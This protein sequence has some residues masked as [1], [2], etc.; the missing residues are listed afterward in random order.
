MISQTKNFIY[1]KPTMQ[2]EKQPN[3]ECQTQKP[4]ILYYET[5]KIK[6]RKEKQGSNRKI[7][8]R[9]EKQ[10]C[11]RKIKRRKERN[12]GVTSCS[13]HCNGGPARSERSDGVLCVQRQRSGVVWARR[14]AC[15]NDM[16]CTWRRGP[17]MLFGL[18]AEQETWKIRRFIS[19]VRTEAVHSLL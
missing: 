11:N 13:S 3:R 14:S 4:R 10:Q 8:R 1:N 15:S 17:T 18:L 9:K 7:K 16:L 19:C 2:P 5:R 6:H 12:R